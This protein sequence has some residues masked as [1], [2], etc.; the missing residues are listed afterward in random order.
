MKMNMDITRDWD[1]LTQFLPEGWEQKAFELRALWRRRK[2]ADAETLLRIMLMHAGEGLS[3]RET[4]VRC[5]EL[6]LAD[7]S[8]VAILHRLRVGGDWVTYLCQGLA[9]EL[10]IRPASVPQ[11]RIL[12]V[13]ASNV[14]EPGPTG[15]CWRLHYVMDLRE[16]RCVDCEVTTQKEAERLDRFAFQPGDLVIADRGY[17]RAKD[18]QH[19]LA[20]GAHAVVR[21]KHNSMKLMDAEGG[22]VELLSHLRGLAAGVT[23]DLP[24]VA[25][26]DGHAISGRLCAVLKSPEAIAREERRIRD[27]RRRKQTK[28]GRADTMEM[29]RYFIVFTTETSAQTGAEEILTWYSWRWQIEIRFKRLKQIFDFGHLPKSDP[30]CIRT[31]LQLKLLLVLLA[32]ALS[33]HAGS[34]SPWGYPLRSRR[35]AS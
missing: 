7:V 24:V 18:V 23:L 28:A 31:W 32:E 13:D 10:G 35:S 2:I 17:S 12:G 5:R 15:S 30:R 29:A 33:R 27:R 14:R 9:G 19:V 25:V 22:T 3:L 1:A 8:D 6:G 20:A 26:V 11:R 16:G 34:F 4:A 21:Y